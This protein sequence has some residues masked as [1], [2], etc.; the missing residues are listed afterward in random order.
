VD[1]AIDNPLETTTLQWQGE[2]AIEPGQF[3]YL[4]LDQSA[5]PNIRSF[6][7]SIRDLNWAPL[8]GNRDQQPDGGAPLLLDV[9]DLSTSKPVRDVVRRLYREGKSANCLSVLRSPL[10]CHALAQALHDRTQLELPDSLHVVLRYFDTRTL[11]LL[12]KLFNTTQYASFMSCTVAWHYLDRYGNMQVLPTANIDLALPDPFVIVLD[13][14]QERLLID[15]GLI[16]GV[17][18]QLLEQRHPELRE[19]SPAEQYE[20][21]APLVAAAGR[22]GIDDVLDAMLFCCAALEHGQDFELQQPWVS[23]LASY[24][25]GKVDLQTAL[26]A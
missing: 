22:F 11:A 23:R 12:P 5:L 8:L 13:Q 15:D 21:V 3:V 6:W 14:A 18:D 24:R 26:F 17:I 20:K 10:E 1:R 2:P 4:L 7:S 9:S 25:L 19:L 16:D